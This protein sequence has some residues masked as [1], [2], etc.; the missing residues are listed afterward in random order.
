MSALCVRYS[1][2]PDGKRRFSESMKLVLQLE[3]GKPRERFVG[4]SGGVSNEE[5]IR[6]IIRI[7]SINL[8]KEKVF[9]QRQ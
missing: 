2:N 7:I 8:T 5:L 3:L 1:R 6:L 9:W 4:C